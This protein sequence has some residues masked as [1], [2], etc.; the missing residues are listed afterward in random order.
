M[1]LIKSYRNVTVELVIFS[2][3]ETS[4][5]SIENDEYATQEGYQII[6]MK[7]RMYTYIYIYIYI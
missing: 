7:M 3:T 6:R 1:Y 2:S 5:V 4:N